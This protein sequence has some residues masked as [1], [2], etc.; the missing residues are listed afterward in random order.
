MHR[1]ARGQGVASALMAR[2]EQEALAQG[3]WLLLLDTET[4]SA[5]QSLYERLGCQVVG[6]VE[7]HAVRPD[8]RL[9]PTTFLS[10]RLR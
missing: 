3:R 7:Y 8:G 2:L 5:A 6:V 10:K 4:G 1:S 9:A